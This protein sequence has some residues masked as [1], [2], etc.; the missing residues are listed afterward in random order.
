MKLHRKN[1][2]FYHLKS[3]SHRIFD[4]YVRFSDTSKNSNH[5]IV[6][7]WLINGA[8]KTKAFIKGLLVPEIKIVEEQLIDPPIAYITSVN[9]M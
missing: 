4:N 7:V 9:V 3:W 8:N 1:P 6:F 5:L 2:S